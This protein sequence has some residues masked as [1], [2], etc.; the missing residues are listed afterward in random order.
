MSLPGPILVVSDR[1]D[2]K[3]MTALAGAGAFPVVDATLAEAAQAIAS[4]QPAAVLFADPDAAPVQRQ[5]DEL[6]DAIDA[7]P[8]PFMPVVARVN[9]CG[10]TIL[11][12]LPISAAAPNEQIIARLAAVLRIRSLHATVLRR[13]DT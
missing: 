4:T 13:I 8:A 9:D 12:V 10:A 11:D 1:P 6:M 2:R 7:M 5:A 3:L